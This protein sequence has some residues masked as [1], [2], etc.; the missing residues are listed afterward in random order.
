MSERKV[1]IAYSQADEDWKI[2]LMKHLRVVMYEG[3]LDPWDDSRIRIGD[4]WDK[5]ILS[6]VN[7][8]TAAILRCPASPPAGSAAR[9]P[10]RTTRS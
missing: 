6:A 7:S 10:L 9:D 2:R 5:S 8:A 1:F 3:D 4:D